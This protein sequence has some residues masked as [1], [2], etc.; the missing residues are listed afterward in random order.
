MKLC[1][2]YVRPHLAQAAL[3]GLIE[4]GCSDVL[5]HE[6]KRVV[7]GLRGEDYAFSLELGQRYE[8]MAVLT[9]LAPDDTIAA[10]VDAVRRTAHTGHHGDGEIVVL[11]VEQRLQ[12][13]T[14][15]TG[16]QP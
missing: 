3:G 1:I 2:A 13:S 9:F 5:V 16:E 15:T 6:A 10:W 14:G 8:A 12:V 7:A 11:P 4:A